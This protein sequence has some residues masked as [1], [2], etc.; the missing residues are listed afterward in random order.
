MELIKSAMI[1]YEAHVI[2]I[3]GCW[4]WK[5]SKNPGGYGKITV[6][7]E[8]KPITISAH[9]LAYTAYR[10]DIPLGKLVLH[11]CDNP[12][13]TNPD[14]LFLGTHQ[15]NMKD[16]I[17]KGRCSTIKSI[18]NAK[19][20]RPQVLY[21]WEHRNSRI[22]AQALAAELGVNEYTVRDIWLK[23]TWKHIT[24]PTPVPQD[25]VSTE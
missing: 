16:K 2:K 23:R 10:G 17:A 4:G 15:D 21:V 1:T 6:R 11:R 3:Q 8:G 19:L 9:R 24:N 5:G 7:I 20:T 22:T 25:V 18:S 12:A 13:C 14:H